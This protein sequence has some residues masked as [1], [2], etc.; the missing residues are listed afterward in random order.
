M[1]IYYQTA[2]ESYPQ[3]LYAKDPAFPGKVA[4]SASFVPTFEPPP[5][6]QETEVLIDEEPS[7]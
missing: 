1:L 6:Q 5:P 2:E 3:L 4:V 7:M